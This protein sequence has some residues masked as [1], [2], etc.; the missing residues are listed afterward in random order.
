M[1]RAGALLC[2]LSTVLALD[3]SFLDKYAFTKVMQHCLGT[4][5]YYRQLSEVAQA[6][7]LCLGYPQKAFLTPSGLNYYFSD[8]RTK[9]IVSSFLPS[10]PGPDNHNDNNPAAPP[11]RGPP[12]T[13]PQ[14]RT[15][16]LAGGPL[17]DANTLATAATHLNAALSNFT[18]VMEFIN[19]VSQQL[20]SRH[21]RVWDG[22]GGHVALKCMWWREK[23][24][25]RH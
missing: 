7:T 13:Y 4:A 17:W 12:S 6:K 18:C 22:T 21:V 2:L 8:R 20:Q 9:R 1:L 16:H 24:C 25:T 3:G 14:Q 19:A 15:Q 10:H 5:N 23:I 11:R